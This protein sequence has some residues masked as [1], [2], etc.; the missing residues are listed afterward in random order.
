MALAVACLLMTPMA[1]SAHKLDAECRL[2]D[3][4]VHVEAYFEDNTPAQQALVRVLD[5]QKQEVIRQKTDAEG[6]CSFDAP[7]PGTYRVV[8]DAG[9][10]HR[11]EQKMIIPGAAARQQ[12]AGTR[13][14]EGPPRE[15]FTRFPWLKVGLGLGT[16]G[17][18]VLA[19]FV[20]RLAGPRSA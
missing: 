5:A 20:A 2:K 16:I 13:V 15:E 4:K 11:A 1:A 12:P 8:V 9:E 17:A 18:V 19:F 6:R 10:G 3:G 14:S 7:A